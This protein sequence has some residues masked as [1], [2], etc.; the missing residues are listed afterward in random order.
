MEFTRLIFSIHFI[1]SIFP[2]K[3]LSS[4]F[5]LAEAD[6]APQPPL[7][8][9]KGKAPQQQR[10]HRESA[11]TGEAAAAAAAAAAASSST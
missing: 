10:N 2:K 3:G 5:L 4:V 9:E 6:V 8:P 7:P 11:A 1:E